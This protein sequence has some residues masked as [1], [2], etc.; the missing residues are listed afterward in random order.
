M[1][2][3]A[4]NSYITT[5]GNTDFGH[6]PGAVEPSNAQDRRRAVPCSVPGD[7]AASVTMGKRYEGLCANDRIWMVRNQGQSQQRR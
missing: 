6:V 5:V 2:G 3:Y 7:V 4:L 1:C